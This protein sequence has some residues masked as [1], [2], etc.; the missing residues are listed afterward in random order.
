[1]TTIRNPK[2]R[3]EKEN[4]DAGV[5]TQKLQNFNTLEK[6]INSNTIS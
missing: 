5:Y 6:I 3:K 4:M 2:K 1:M